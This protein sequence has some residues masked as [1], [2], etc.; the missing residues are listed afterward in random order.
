[1]KWGFRWYGAAGDAIPLKHIRQIPGITGVVGTL[2]NKL[3]VM[4]GQ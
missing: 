3:P 1:M 2:L 4:F